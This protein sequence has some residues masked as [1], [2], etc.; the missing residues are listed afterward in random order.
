MDGVFNSR[1]MNLEESAEIILSFGDK[2]HA[3]EV[4]AILA[5]KSAG[6]VQRV[7]DEF[8]NSPEG[9]SVNELLRK[10]MPDREFCEIF[11]RKQNEH[12]AARQEKYSTLS[13]RQKSQILTVSTELA[14]LAEKEEPVPAAED[15]ADDYPPVKA[16]RLS[17]SGNRK[18]SK[19]GGSAGLP[20]HLTWPVNSR[21]EKMAFIGRIGLSELET[22]QCALKLPSKGILYL[23]WDLED[24]LG[25]DIFWKVIFSANEEV[26]GDGNDGLPLG[27]KPITS[28][29]KAGNSGI[30]HALSL[31]LG[32][33]HQLGGYPESLPGYP[34]MRL[35]C[36][37]RYGGNAGDWTLLLQFS[38]DK[39]AELIW[40]ENGRAFFWIKKSDLENSNFDQT[41]M[42]IQS[43]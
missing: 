36:V 31:L 2:S 13:S 32:S 7:V 35:Q 5:G 27:F 23:F 18:I 42:I 6:D 14:E 22:D 3:R 1:L 10:L 19:L 20:G 40:Y 4:E 33:H 16:Y 38:E 25:G 11:I 43:F 39:K 34:D 12:I 30:L 28:K 24:S 26:S 15:D 8:N 17:G 29:W 37:E 9:K 41:V 21:G